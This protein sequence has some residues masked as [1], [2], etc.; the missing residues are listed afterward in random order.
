MYMF[1]CLSL[2]LY[3]SLCDSFVCF[4]TVVSPYF[5]NAKCHFSF[6]F[7]NEQLLYMKSFALFGTEENY[8]VM[9]YTKYLSFIICFFFYYLILVVVLRLIGTFRF[10]FFF[11]FF[12]IIVFVIS[13]E[14]SV[15]SFLR[16]P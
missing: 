11:F 3:I 14:I 13:G 12:R 7:I 10:F 4:D 15:Y 2:F 9:N 6:S 16:E 5:P 1:A 8:N